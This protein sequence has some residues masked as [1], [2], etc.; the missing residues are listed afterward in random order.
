MPQPP[1]L[2]KNENKRERNPGEVFWAT[3]F[4]IRFIPIFSY[5]LLILS[6]CFVIITKY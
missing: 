3:A 5:F 4:F 6:R 2:R 1:F